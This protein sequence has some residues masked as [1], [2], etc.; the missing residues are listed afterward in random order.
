MFRREPNERIPH[1]VRFFYMNRCHR[2][3][4]L[5][6]DDGLGKLRLHALFA[7]GRV[8]RDGD[9]GVDKR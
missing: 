7:V 5:A 4:M 6:L 2:K 1:M 3:T 9:I 8:D